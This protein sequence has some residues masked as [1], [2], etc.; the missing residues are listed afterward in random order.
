MGGSG[1]SPDCRPY[2]S[3]ASCAQNPTGQIPTQT[4]AA[5]HVAI[6]QRWLLCGTT[7]IFGNS[8]GDIGLEI[9]PEG[10]WYRLYPGAG[11]SAVRGSGFDEEGKWETVSAGG[12]GDPQPYQ[13]NFHILASG[14]IAT[15]PSFAATPRAMRL[16]NNGV[17]I[18]NYVLDASV[19]SGGVRC[20]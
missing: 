5:F 9:T 7:S 19:P 12:P 2:T 13:L 4:V 3:P 8:R 15:R 17:F 10:L 6:S 18:A 14:M 11:G 20:P 1:G 16:N